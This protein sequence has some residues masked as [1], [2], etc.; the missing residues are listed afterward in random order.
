MIC[1]VIDVGSDGETGWKVGVSHLYCHGQLAKL[2]RDVTM[3]HRF[4]LR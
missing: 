2:E 3:Y 1:E 4:T